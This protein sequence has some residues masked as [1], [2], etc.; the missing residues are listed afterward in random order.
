[1]LRHGKMI[2]GRDENLLRVTVI[3]Q[4]GHRAQIACYG[5]KG[6]ASQHGDDAHHDQHLRQRKA[7]FVM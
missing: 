7:L 3:F 4:L 1:M 5:N 6:Y 2:L